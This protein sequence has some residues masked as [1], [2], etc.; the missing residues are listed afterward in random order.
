MTADEARVLIDETVAWS[1]AMPAVADEAQTKEWYARRERVSE[2]AR[3]MSP[4][5]YR[6][7]VP[8]LA[9]G[10][11]AIDI[12]RAWS[13]AQPEVAAKLLVDEADAGRLGA[14]ARYCNVQSYDGME[15]LRSQLKPH[16]A[17][18]KALVKTAKPGPVVRDLERLAKALG[19]LK[20]ADVKKIR[21]GLRAGRDAAA[22]SFANACRPTVDKEIPGLVPDLVAYVRGARTRSRAWERAV[23]ELAA[24]AATVPFDVAVFLDIL[25]KSRGTNEYEMAL[26]GVKNAAQR[27][28]AAGDQAGHDALMAQRA[29]YL[30]K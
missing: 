23:F 22:E 15:A 18:I 12:L 7:L 8:Y 11:I 29:T 5:D 1:R 6:A 26:T 10:N 25:A 20:A 21:E 27:L 13:A 30:T 3:T 28:Q 14:L 17:R 24:L 19:G 4:E 2:A 9:D 16:V